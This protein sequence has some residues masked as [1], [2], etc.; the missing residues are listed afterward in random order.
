LSTVYLV[1]HGQ[2]GTR[3]AYDSLSQLG[4]IQARRLG[5]HFLSQGINFA[6]ACRGALQRQRETGEEVRAAYA[7][8]GV[9]FPTIAVVPEWNE[10]DL[11]HV[12]R[13]MAPLL[14]AE[15]D[16]FRVE[17][18]KMLEQVRS[19]RREPGAAIHRKWLPCDTKIVNAWISGRY[20]YSGEKWDQFRERITSRRFSTGEAEGRENVVVF[21]SATPVAIWTG[22]S[23]QIRD[24]R[25]MQLAGV[26]YNASYTVLRLREGQLRLFTFN[27]APH[28]A[29]DG[30]RT[31]R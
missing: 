4:K 10:F 24:E 16:R 11:A 17:Y 19:S 25:V 22:L 18:E 27:A 14:S 12:Y 28:L 15:D 23:L 7:G 30:L 6:S 9:S 26:L 20:P 3:E 29:A 1:R 8:A 21:T 13:E 31:H 2:A 5:E